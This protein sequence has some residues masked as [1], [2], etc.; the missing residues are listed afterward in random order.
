MGSPA[1]M[2]GAEL[3]MLYQL[4]S[5]DR[6]GLNVSYNKGYYVDKPAAF[7]S[8]VANSD[9]AGVVPWTVDANYS[10]MFSLPK[11]QN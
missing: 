1:R 4:T 8:G 7:A 3:E 6:F 10:H 11:D 5:A 9:M 2:Y